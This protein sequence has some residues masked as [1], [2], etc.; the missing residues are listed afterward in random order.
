MRCLLLPPE[1]LP[2]SNPRPPIL[3]SSASSNP[4]HPPNLL[5]FQSHHL[6]DL[7][8]GKYAAQQEDYGRDEVSVLIWPGG[9]IEYVA[10][11]TTAGDIAAEK[12]LG[13]MAGRGYPAGEV[14]GS[15]GGGGRGRGREWM[16]LRVGVSSQ[17]S[18]LPPPPLPLT[19]PRLYVTSPPSPHPLIS[20]SPHSLA[21][22]CPHPHA[23]RWAMTATASTCSSTST[24]AWCPRTR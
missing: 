23:P 8:A 20:S 12:G 1:D 9:N 21:P 24:T 6:L 2:P 11:G 5:I 22:S 10:R 18:H 15:G 16:G 14:R 17:V 19:K 7:L 4:P 3:Q 13:E